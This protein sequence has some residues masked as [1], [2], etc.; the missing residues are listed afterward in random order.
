MTGPPVGDAIE[1]FLRS[2]TAERDLSPHT[3]AAYRRDLEALRAWLER[4]GIDL[5]SDLDR[6]WLRR[7]V[8]Y[9]SQRGYARRTISRKV[10]ALRSLLRWAVRRG[11]LDGDPSAGLSVPKLDR[12]L[13]RVLRQSEAAALCEAPPEDSPEGLRDR[14]VLE[15]LY[16]C[17][18][19]VSELCGLDVDDVDLRRR[20]LVVLGKGRKQR[21][22]P[23]GAPAADALQRYLVQARP[24]LAARGRSDAAPGEPALFLNTRGARLS[25]RRVRAILERYLGAEHLPVVGPHTLRHSFATHLLDNG[26]DLRAVQEL[27]GHESLATTQVYTHVS[28]ERL[29]QVYEQSHPRA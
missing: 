21:R 3:V 20:S 25:R 26:A 8:A 12:P 2:C 9:L 19:R 14:A 17:G 24:A 16:G 10:S 18:L 23:F 28:T 27:L 22:L 1:D 7:Y 13:P 29:K 6:Q 4:A 15:L 11:V 5:L